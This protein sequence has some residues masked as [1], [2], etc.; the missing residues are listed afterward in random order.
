[1]KHTNR[2]PEEKKRLINRLKRIEGQVRGIIKMVENDE[3]CPNILNQTSSVN[4][5]INSF[6]KDL[7]GKHIKECV[8]N[9]IKNGN[10]EVLDE[11]VLTLQRLM[12]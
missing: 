8:L 4:A 6:N 2:N 1:M 9:D 11:L 5:A 7:V 3:Y 10:E 12:K